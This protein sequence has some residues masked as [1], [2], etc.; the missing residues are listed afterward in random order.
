M[1]NQTSN[2][3]V[4]PLPNPGEGGPVA[5]PSEG[6]NLPVV[7]LPDVG[8]GGPVAPGPG[9]ENYPVVPLP[10]PGEGG[11]VAPGPGDGN[12]PVVPLPNPG[13]GGPVAPQ[14]WPNRP[15]QPSR[16]Q[17][18]AAVR[19]LNAAYGYAP[20]RIFVQNTRMVRLLNYAAASSYL[21]IPAGYQTV[22]VTGANGYIYLQK[23]LPFPQN[24]RSTVAIVNTA[25]GLDL[26][27][28]PDTCCAPARGYGGFRVSNLARNSTPLDVLLADGR[29][30][31]ADVRFKETTSFKQIR[32]GSYQFYFAETSL[33]PMPDYQDI[34][35]L[36]AAFIGTSPAVQT[37]ATLYLRVRQSVQYT[38]FLL[39]SGS[40]TNAVQTLVLEN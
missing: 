17:P 4:V 9:E 38:V 5:N 34:E 30:V 32:P 25:G 33:M 19:F 24:A 23:T 11:P 21:R 3:P 20:F 12:Y 15:T 1:S 36:D 37:A 16:P 13:E 7:P 29:V 40:A 35:T 6:E 10:N 18:Y 8:E 14:P 31:Y 39:S 22:T 27:Q 28:I 2:T 26:L